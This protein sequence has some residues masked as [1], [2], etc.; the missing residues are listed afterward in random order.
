VARPVFIP[1]ARAG[2]VAPQSARP[3]LT[4][5]EALAA[6]TKAHAAKAK[7]TPKGAPPGAGPARAPT[8]PES[9]AVQSPPPELDAALVSVPPEEAASALAQAGDGAA[10]L[11]DAWAAASNAAALVEAAESEAVAGPSRKAARRAIAVLRSRGVTIPARVRATRPGAEAAPIEASFSAPDALGTVMFT[12]SRREAS[13]S[14]RV[15]EVVLREPHGI[16]QA[17]AG[18]VSG[19]QLK[20]RRSRGDGQAPV[21]V[22]VPLEWARH[23]IAEARKQNV[24]SGVVVPLGFDRCRDLVDPPSAGGTPALPGPESAPAHPL[25]DLESA[26]TSDEVAASVPLSANLQGEPELR[27]WSVDRATLEELLVKVGE[28]L[29]PEGLANREAADAAFS[30]EIS[31]ATDR[32]FSPEVRVVVASRMRDAAIS[33]R[34]RKGDRAA[35]EVLAVARA[36]VEAGLIT[37][38][39]RDIPFLVTFF[40]VGLSYLAAQAGGRI[41]IPVRQPAPATEVVSEAVG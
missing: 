1:L 33:V 29:G 28:R 23:R 24:A 22:P 39:P 21:P 6:K 18:W 8:E 4:P 25:S 2:Q 36:V 19:S 14:Y 15:A 9:A 40:Q 7:Q 38:P 32:F 10:A 31:A 12:L 13:G 17:G 34:S 5:K 30:E 11:I 16:L 3:A 35:A 37:S 41:S 26:L 20:D 27:G